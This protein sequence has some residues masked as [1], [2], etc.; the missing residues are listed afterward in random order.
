[1][2]TAEIGDV[3]IVGNGDYLLIKTAGVERKVDGIGK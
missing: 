2:T 1:M 3:D